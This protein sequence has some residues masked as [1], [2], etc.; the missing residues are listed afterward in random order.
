MKLFTR[1]LKQ[2][3][4]NFTTD[5]L[6]AYLSTQAF[7][8]RSFMT[9][10]THT[11]AQKQHERQLN[12]TKA[13]V[14]FFFHFTATWSQCGHFGNLSSSFWCGVD[15]G[16]YHNDRYSLCVYHEKEEEKVRLHP[17]SDS[18]IHISIYKQAPQNHGWIFYW[19]MLHTLSAGQNT[20]LIQ[21]TYI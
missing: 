7:S 12:K 18:S 11:V 21:N 3:P 20:E 16:H 14:P 19:T 10:K 2:K 4:Q 17:W 8:F 13:K 15:C 6:K 9:R 5:T 1:P